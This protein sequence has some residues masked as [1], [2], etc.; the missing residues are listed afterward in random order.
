MCSVSFARFDIVV[1]DSFETLKEDG[2]RRYR[3]PFCD[4][5]Q[6]RCWIVAVQDAGDIVRSVS[7]GRMTED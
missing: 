2:I 4:I 6:N 1:N 3:I 5:A 7:D